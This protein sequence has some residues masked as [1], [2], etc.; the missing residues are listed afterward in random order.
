MKFQGIADTGAM[1]RLAT[2]VGN[3]CH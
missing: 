2:G 3:G 1:D